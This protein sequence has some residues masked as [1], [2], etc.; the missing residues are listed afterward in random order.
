MG[1]LVLGFQEI[2]QTQ[3]VLVGGKGLH[4]GKLSRLEGVNVPEGFCI[5]TEA[6]RQATA[7]NEAYHALLDQLAIL[8]PDDREPIRDI[9]SKIRQAITER[10][11]PAEVADAVGGYL[12]C[13]GEEHAYAVRSSATAEDLPHASFAGQQDSYLNIRGRAAILDHIRQCW[14]SLFTDRAVVYRMQNGFPHHQVYAAVIVQRMAYPEASG[15]LFTADPVTSNRTVLS[16]DAGFGL[17]EAMVSGLVSAD[18]YTVQNGHITGKRLAAKHQAVYARPEGGTEIRPVD[19]AR[20]TSPALSDVEILE[21][22]HIGRRIEAYLGCPQDIEWCLA[23][24]V[25]YI[26][27]SRP[28]TTLFPV[29]ETEDGGKHVYLSAGHQQMMTDPIKPLG[30][31]FFL[32]VTPARM[33]TAGGRLFVDVAPML[34]SPATRDMLLT[35]FGQ[36]D[37]LIKDALLNLIE[38]DYI[39]LLS[40]I[41]EASS[42]GKQENPLPETLPLPEPGAELVSALIRKTEDSLAEL[43]RN[44]S[45][46]SGPALFEFILGDIPVLKS[47]LFDPQ[48]SSVYMAAM[49]AS[50]W[51]NEHMNQWLGE[52]GAA[53]TLSQSVPHNITSEMGLALLELAD[54][55]R[56]YPQVIAY[57]QQA[58]SSSFL[59]ELDPLEGGREVKEAFRDFLG[60]YGMRCPGEIDIT[61]TRWSEHPL[62]LVPLL[63]GNLKQFGPDA[64]KR[65]F[66]QGRQAARDK[67]RELLERIKLLPG[68]GEKAAEAQR[69]I[70][71]LRTCSG[72]REYPKYGMICR[73]FVYKQALLGEAEQLV[74]A[75]V[76]REKEDMYYLTFEELHE[77][78]RTQR[79]D[80]AIIGRRKEEYRGYEKLTPPRV[81]T[82][83][84]EIVTGAY[85]RENLPDR[86]VIG[87]PVSAG[88]AEGRARVILSLEDARLE[89]GDILI[90]SFTD[91]GWTPLFISI[92]ALVTEVGGLMTHGAVI[93][94]EYGLP[95][96]VG[97]ENATRLIKDGQRIRVNGTDG[98]IEILDEQA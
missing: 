5:T 2:G 26:L 35:S 49:N 21:L 14:A 77:A 58:K 48:A 41:N 24:G 88:V 9:C 96:V 94:R 70:R 34:A 46:K 45:A 95:A 60:Q 43:K 27:Q 81:M 29:P 83:E 85:K 64:G 3:L 17:G 76:I 59:E 80:Y 37:P 61:R 15:I 92:K 63:L 73:Y 57:L 18:G 68:G 19:P 65:K 10:E 12:C 30:L 87:L 31:S 7:H 8:K 84:G 67:E 56:P 62:A 32:K 25:F 74:Q 89:E 52:K 1:S 40:D 38:R 11:I 66:E 78:V 16:I 4:L 28:I 39:P 53:D 50:V 44:I 55:I 69:K 91:P 75:Q 72:F 36:S 54:V 42:A 79:L 23:D 98:Y 33:R 22:A 13:L 47:F 93:A 82:S 97:V 6:F 71:I 51:L 86:A 20:Q 90:T